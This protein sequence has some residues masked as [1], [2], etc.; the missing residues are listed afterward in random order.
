M[1]IQIIEGLKHLHKNKI[2]HRD[3]KEMNILIDG[4]T[5]IQI[6]DFGL[7]HKFANEEET[8]NNCCGTPGYWAPE[9]VK[10]EQYRMMPDWWALGVII[11]KLMERKGPFDA[12]GPEWK[13]EGAD[14][15][16]IL[17]KDEFRKKLSAEKDRRLTTEEPHPFEKQM[18][19]VDLK[20]LVLKLLTKDPAQRIGST[21][22][23]DEILEHKVFTKEFIQKAK[24]GDYDAPAKP[25]LYDFTQDF[26]SVDKKNTIAK[27]LNCFN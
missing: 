16:V 25:I 23:A 20:D 19:S 4:N 22:D 6:C 27:A 5:N 17:E 9:Q 15:A 14:G 12:V 11:Y 8:V 2:V 1:V 18:Y 26:N 10:R 21:N 13:N 24:D 7:A 3:M